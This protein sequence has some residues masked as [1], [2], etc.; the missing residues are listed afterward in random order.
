M[1]GLLREA[2]PGGLQGQSQAQ[3]GA[4]GGMA[5][6]PGRAKTG[7]QR[8]EHRNETRRCPDEK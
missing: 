4:G 8:R 3:G 5:G 7:L 2:E 1:A 6:T